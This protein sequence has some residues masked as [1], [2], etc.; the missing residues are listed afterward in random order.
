M[1]KDLAVK[2]SYYC[3]DM[4]YTRDLIARLFLTDFTDLP[5]EIARKVI[6][7]MTDEGICKDFNM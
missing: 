3:I 7:R 2:H 4:L 5:L 1:I 6:S